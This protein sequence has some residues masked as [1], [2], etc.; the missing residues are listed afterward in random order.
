[1]ED[2]VQSLDEIRAEKQ[3]ELHLC[4]GKILVWDADDVKLLRQTHHIVGS[5][6]GS[7][8][9]SPR[10][11]AQLGLP[12]QLMPEEAAV[13]IEYDVAKMVNVK[14]KDPSADNVTSFEEARQK[15][16]CEQQT[17]WDTVNAKK[18]QDFANI[19]AL[20]RTTKKHRRAERAKKQKRGKASSSVESRGDSTVRCASDSYKLLE[21]D[22]ATRKRRKIQ[23][24]FS[25]VAEVENQE[26]SSAPSLATCYAEQAEDV[27]SENA[28][29]TRSRLESFLSNMESSQLSPADCA[30]TNDSDADKNI[31][32]DVET[33]KLDAVKGGLREIKPF[34]EVDSNVA[35]NST[36]GHI[37]KDVHI[38]EVKEEEKPSTV[39]DG[40]PKAR[41]TIS[42]QSMEDDFCSDLLPSE[43]QCGTSGPPG[44]VSDP[45]PNTATDTSGPAPA[46]LSSPEHRPDDGDVFKKPPDPRPC[47]GYLVHIVTASPSTPREEVTEWMYPTSQQELLKYRV[48]RDLWEMG[49]YL[50]SG[51]KFGGDFL[52]YPGKHCR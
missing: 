13:L 25:V 30:R 17:M 51:C 49:Y 38:D 15:S 11:N 48:F 10:Q 24:D 34:L 12:L 21:E 45:G 52:V 47:S 35:D 4:K 27:T 43:Q 50:T 32:R 41:L 14:I 42:Q 40:S 23:D 39:T 6:V 20:G 44:V 9:R 28:E 46:P 33:V 19:I 36:V 7:L 5:L 22:G 29:S 26:G 1:M 3:I 2:D 8:P 31:R 18:K 16:F 37:Q